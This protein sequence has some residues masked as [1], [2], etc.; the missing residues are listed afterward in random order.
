MGKK[1]TNQGKKEHKKQGKRIKEKIQNWYAAHNN[2]GG[3]VGR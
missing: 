3:E 1:E 2:P